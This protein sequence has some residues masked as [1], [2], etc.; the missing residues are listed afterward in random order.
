MNK[1]T[2]ERWLA[3]QV[4]ESNYWDG[5]NV[6]EL[7][8]ICAEK[9]AFLD[10][11]GSQIILSLFDQR[12]VLEIGVGPLGISI[13]SFYANKRK[14]KRLVK[15]EPLER[16]LITD[17][18]IMR[19]VWAKAFLEW[20]HLLSEEGEYI[21]LPGEQMDYNQEFD[22]VIIYNVLDHVKEPLSILRNT[23]N[24]LR[25]DGQILVGVDCKS[26]LGRIKFEYILRRIRKGEILVEAHPHTFLP[27]HVVRMLNDSGFQD[28]QT[29]GVPGLTHSF[30]GKN[31]RPAFIGKKCS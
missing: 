5:F 26:L 15:V 21:Q 1:I 13:A 27:H 31:Y 29:V 24:A 16:R 17:S 12:E 20:V 4:A 22:T 11:V 8:R 3:A 19:E 7:L 23:Y 18:L 6:T 30:A 28:V 10:S 14:I 2:Q 25:K 9:P